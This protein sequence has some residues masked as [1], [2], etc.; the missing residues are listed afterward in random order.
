MVRYAVQKGGV[1]P[2]FEVITASHFGVNLVTIYDEEFVIADPTLRNN[3]ADLGARSLRFPGG[4]ATEFYF[5][6]TNPN[7][8]QSSYDPSETLTP[9]D[10][11]FERAGDLGLEAT[12]VLP[13]RLAF[14][15]TAGT[16]MID[17]SYGRRDTLSNGYLSD[18]EQFVR[19]TLAYSN[20]F[21]VQITA[22]EVGN[23]FWGSGQMTATEYGHVAGRVAMLVADILEDEGYFGPRIAVQS[24][25]AASKIFSSRDDVMVYVNTSGPEE[26]FLSV[27]DATA[28]YSPAE[29]ADWALVSLSGQGSAVD[30]VT[31]IT[32][33]INAVSGAADKIGAVVQHSYETGG[34]DAVDG[35]KD[36]KYGQFQSFVDQLVRS[37]DVPYVEFH[38]T[39]WNTRSYG[40]DHNRGLQN[41]SMMI[42]NFYEMLTNG[43]D[44]AQIWPLSFDR[45]Q[46]LSLVDIDEDDLSIAGEMFALMSESLIGKTPIL[47]WS[48]SGQ[49]DIHGFADDLETV[50]FVSERSGQSVQN[51]SLDLSDILADGFY[52]VTLT[53]LWDGGAGGD[54]ANAEPVLTAG[55]FTLS[56][57][58]TLIFDLAAWANVRIELERDLNGLS[59]PVDESGQ[60]SPSFADASNGDPVPVGVLADPWL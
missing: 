22:F 20:A 9:L 16:A 40:A 34:F 37:G 41:A 49:I 31:Q 13:T 29:L 6:L 2:G 46:G 54:N 17:G 58:D 24:T 35:G 12:I 18:L 27:E 55:G 19:Q 25:S 15:V 48:V 33:S 59:G 14:G 28:R 44:A 56:Q 4:S 51:V 53:Q 10:G 11:F 3:V 39:E 60:L 26:M 42:E 1:M 21:G 23:E 32:Q 52:S 36:F 38:M 7:A 30:Q 45:A 43:V 5:D 47:D 57:L 50:L 8:T